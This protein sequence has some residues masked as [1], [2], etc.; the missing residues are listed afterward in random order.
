MRD[1][2][3]IDPD[4]FAIHSMNLPDP[5]FKR[6]FHTVHAAAVDSKALGDA[7]T[8]CGFLNV[9]HD[10]GKAA[11]LVGAEGVDGLAGDVL[12]L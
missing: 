10:M 7:G 11:A 6:G 12:M 4:L 9:L 3:Q 1:G 8:R 2:T 5:G